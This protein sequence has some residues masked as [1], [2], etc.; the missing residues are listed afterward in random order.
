AGLRLLAPQ[1]AIS[2]ENARLYFQL[3][4]ENG[5]R[6]RAEEELRKSEERWRAVFESSALG[7]AL[8]DLSGRFVAV[9]P[10][11]RSM[12]GYS[13]AELRELSFRMITHEDDRERNVDLVAEMIE[14]KRSSFELVKRYRRSD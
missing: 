1:A 11:Y 6:A 13:E 4:Q 12:L 2:R 8:T 10:A 5:E 7:I 14:G 9:N 3:R